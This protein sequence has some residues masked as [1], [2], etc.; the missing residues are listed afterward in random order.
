MPILDKSNMSDR[1]QARLLALRH[2]QRALPLA[3]RVE[4]IRGAIGFDPLR[5][6]L[7]AVAPWMPA[8]AN[9]FLTDDRFYGTAELI[10][11]CQGPDWSFRLRL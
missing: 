4:T 1:H 2:G 7:D 6:L 10:S 8:N 9:V 5:A 11:L 3:W